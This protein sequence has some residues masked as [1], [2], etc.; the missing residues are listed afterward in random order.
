MKEE[1]QATQERSIQRPRH[2]DRSR[3]REQERERVKVREKQRKKERE[4][5]DRDW[6]VEMGCFTPLVFSTAGGMG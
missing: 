5:G 4:Y 1:A 2:R 3:G 6:E